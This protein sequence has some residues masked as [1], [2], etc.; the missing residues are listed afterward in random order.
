MPAEIRT[1]NEQPVPAAPWFLQG[2]ACLSLWRVP[3][4][5]LPPPPASTR[6]VRIAGQALLVTA[7]VRYGP[8]GT[9]TY[10]ELAVA[11][12]VQGS[13]V[14]GPACTVPYIWVDDATAAAGGRQLWGIPKE[15]AAFE[16][17]LT[18]SK[19]GIAVRATTGDSP[20]ASMTMAPR[21]ALPGRVP[22]RGYIVQ[23]GAGG[24]IRTLCAARARLTLGRATWNFAPEGP[25]AFLRRRKPLLSLQV[26]EVQARF[27]L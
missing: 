23:D 18:P 27:G 25:L 26:S 16:G 6:Y 1:P 3:T 24:P 9:L 5:V 21:W 15:L 22:V 4:A 2:D 19:D 13:G 10:G 20:L 14:P 17:E 8:G 11:A 7:W 12:L